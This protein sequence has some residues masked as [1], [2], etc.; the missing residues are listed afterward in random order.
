MIGRQ[1][2]QT[3]PCVDLEEAK[4]EACP[5]PP[6]SGMR[7]LKS[8]KPLPRFIK[9]VSITNTLGDI[10]MNYVEWTKIKYKVNSRV[11]SSRKAKYYTIRDTG[12]GSFLYILND[13]F[14]KL[15]SVSGIYESPYDVLSFEGCGEKQLEV[16]CNPWDTP[17]YASSST[18]DNICKLAW[19]VLPTVRNSAPTDPLNNEIDDT[20]GATNLKL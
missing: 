15:V 9:L 16:I 18:I 12:E 3:I 17:F 2:V 19:Q 8:K 10:N 13:D 14:L 5:C 4:A 6:P 1:D 11:K 20:A 7:W